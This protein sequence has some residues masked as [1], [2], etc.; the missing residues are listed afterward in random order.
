M[1]RRRIGQRAAPVVSAATPVI[2]A[3]GPPCG[4]HS[5]AMRHYVSTDTVR[6]PTTRPLGAMPRMSTRT[7]I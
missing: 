7:R 3:P 4:L 6:R 2:S 1:R 5:P